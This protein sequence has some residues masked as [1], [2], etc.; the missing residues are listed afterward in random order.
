MTR[1]FV[2]TG[3]NKGIGYAIVGILCRTVQN[4]VIYLTC[5]RHAMR[6]AS[7]Q[8]LLSAQYCAWRSSDG[9]IEARS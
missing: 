9:E 6:E 2:V 7:K 4:A 3:A 8:T 5:E 1:V